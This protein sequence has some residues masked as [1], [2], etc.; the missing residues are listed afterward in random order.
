[1]SKAIVAVLAVALIAV[2]AYVSVA[3][4]EVCLFLG[5]SITLGARTTPAIVKENER[6]S[7]MVAR[8]LNC[9]EVNA[10]IS[11]DT[12][13]GGI[14]RL[15]GLLAAR[16]FDRIFVMFG[17]NDAHW[18]VSPRDYER[19]MRKIIEAARNSG[20]QVTLLTPPA[21]KNPHTSARL[22]YFVGPLREFPSAY[23]DIT[24]VDIYDVYQR[25]RRAGNLD[26]LL[27]D[28]WHPTAQGHQVIARAIMGGGEEAR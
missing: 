6:F 25:E 23:P 10:G 27:M 15:P 26:A 1:M 16:R 4:Q 13:I 19:S 18:G 17:T 8:D 12:S 20:A 28:D 14:S 24:L 9:V 3:S 7:Y 22:P 2:A 11:R 21:S 5:D